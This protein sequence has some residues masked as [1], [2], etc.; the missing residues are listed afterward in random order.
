M[1]IKA[2]QSS[3]SVAQNALTPPVTPAVICDGVI[4]LA[5]PSGKER[6]RGFQPP[7]RTVWQY[8]CP[9][10]GEKHRVGASSFFGSRPVSSVGAIRCGRAVNAL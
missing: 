1:N 2:E 7:W 6:V 4:N 10:C 5:T 3:F 8:T 9:K